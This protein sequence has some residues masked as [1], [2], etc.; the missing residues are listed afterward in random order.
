MAPPKKGMAESSSVPQGKPSKLGRIQKSEGLR[1]YDFLFPMR[2][3]NY[4]VLSDAHIEKRPLLHPAITS[5]YAGA[6]HE[7]AVYVSASTPFI[8]AV[9]RVRKFLDNIEKRSRQSELRSSSGKDLN[10]IEPNHAPAKKKGHEPEEVVLKATGKA[11]ER[12]LELALYFQRQPDCRVV[13]RTGS[14]GTVDDIVYA[15][16]PGDDGGEEGP[17][18]NSTMRDD[19]EELPETQIR[20]ASTID[21]GVSLR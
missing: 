21:I 11:I 3:S 20:K 5:P 4:L 14:V 9:K 2:C 16:E 13:I 17:D 10:T 7:K 18:G 12:A 15:R 1:L 19:R 8:A 6:S